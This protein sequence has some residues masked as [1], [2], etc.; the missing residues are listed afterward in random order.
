M[1][2]FVCETDI[3]LELDFELFEQPSTRKRF[4]T[5][6]ALKCYNEFIFC[7]WS[8]WIY[9]NEKGSRMKKIIERRKENV[10]SQCLH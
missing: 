3:E 9:E 1:R 5:M 8:M 10:L 7:C 6:F 2:Y 4:F